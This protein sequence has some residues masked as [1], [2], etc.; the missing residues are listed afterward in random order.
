M[1]KITTALLFLSLVIGTSVSAQDGEKTDKKEMKTEKKMKK[2]KHQ[3][4]M[5]KAHKMEK[6]DDKAK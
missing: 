4:A 5:K 6:K 2:G 3:R 1:K